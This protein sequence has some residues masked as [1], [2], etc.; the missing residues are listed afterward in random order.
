MNFTLTAEEALVQQTARDFAE[1]ELAPLAAGIDRAGEVPRQV[2]EKMASL[3]FLGMLTPGASGGAG[4]NTFCLSLIQIEIS[5][6]C[7]PTALALSAHNALC[8][9]PILAFGNEA[10][11]KKYLPRLARGLW[12]GAHVLSGP[13][14]PAARDGNDFILDGAPEPVVNGGFADV[15]V[16]AVRTPPR[17][18]SS[19]VVVERGMKG[20]STLHFRRKT[21]AAG[22]NL[23]FRK[24]RV[25]R[26]N[27]LG[28]EGD[29]KRASDYALDGGRIGVAARAV[30]I[31]Q[32]CLDASMKRA[33]EVLPSAGLEGVRDMLATMAT[34]IEA[35]RLLVYRAARLRDGCAKHVREASMAKLFATDTAVRHAA[36]AVQLH[37]GADAVRG[38]PV[39][40]HLRE[41]RAAE[42]CW[43]AA[44]SHRIAIAQS[45][46]K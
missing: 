13:P 4:L 5:R 42:T 31:A 11:K 15:F 16:C 37:G 35:S 19:V 29:G 9:G 26:A 21:D 2:L 30:G 34:E 24:C 46:L 45:L 20:F 3:G 17:N 6:V 44:E 12:I 32:A 8:Q 27:L 22:A 43:G 38:L 25:P 1:R 33:R 39:E 14:V 40:R 28:R 18:A 23:S 36:L 41:A 7:A 10:Q